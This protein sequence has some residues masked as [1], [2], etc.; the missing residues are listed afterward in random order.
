MD[1]LEAAVRDRGLTVFA[2]VDHAAG[3]AEVGLELRP[4]VLLVFGNAKGGTPL[5][6]ADQTMGIE[7][8]LKALVWEDADHH[9]WLTYVEPAW[10]VGRHGIAAK[11]DGVA[12]QMTF[13]LEALT[14]AATQA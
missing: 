4:T 3:A 6:V 1:R 12:S 7:L 14:K 13:L 8:P 5:M 9:T 11:G 10:L 2:R